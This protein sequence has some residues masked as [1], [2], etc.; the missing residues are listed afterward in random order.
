M[1]RSSD[2]S[3]RSAENTWVSVVRGRVLFYVGKA[4]QPS[5]T[6]GD[7]SIVS[8]IRYGD[9]VMATLKNGKLAVYVIRNGRSISGPV[10]IISG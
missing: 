7:G 9:E 5:Q 10:R 2:E 1:Q 3:R 8:A 4:S 6:F